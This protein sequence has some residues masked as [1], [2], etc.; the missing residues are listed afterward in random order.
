MYFSG[1]GSG[2]CHAGGYAGYGGAGGSIAVLDFPYG[3]IASSLAVTVGAGGASRTGQG[4]PGLTGGTTIFNGYALGGGIGGFTGFSAVPAFAA[5]QKLSLSGNI[6]NP[7]EG[8]ATLLIGGF[9]RASANDPTSVNPIPNAGGGGGGGGAGVREGFT[10]RTTQNEAA[11][12]CISGLAGNGGNGGST[13]VAGT[14]PSGGGG[15]SS[16][17]N[18]N[19]T[20]GA[21]ARGEM[22]IY[23][24]RGKVPLSFFTG[25]L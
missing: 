2:G 3:T 10:T 17:W 16:L 22:R 23:V 15:G 5:A 9:G 24:V 11:G 13:G 20:S 25:I 1:G 18:A 8:M 21:G 19:S 14:A 4:T 12:V 6:S 7:N